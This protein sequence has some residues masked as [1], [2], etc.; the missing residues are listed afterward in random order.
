MKDI[1]ASGRPKKALHSISVTV[2]AHGTE[3]ESNV[4]VALRQIVPEGV[5]VDRLEVMGHFGNPM[6]ILTARTE[7]ANDT[8]HIIGTIT[9]KL[10]KDELTELREQI[11][12]HLNGCTLVLK[13]DKQ[14]AA[15]GFLRRGKEDPIV[16]RAKIAAYPARVQNAMRMI[17]DLFD[18]A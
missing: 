4:L 17:R 16:L 2:F 15:R 3:N 18:D 13:F 1:D 10:P 9:T 6:V 11:P 14:A 5:A 7:K 8:R 12:Q